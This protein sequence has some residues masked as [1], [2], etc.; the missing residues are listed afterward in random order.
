M[1]GVGPAVAGDSFRRDEILSSPSVSRLPIYKC[2][3]SVADT[4]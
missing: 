2:N 4:I 3:K 1:D